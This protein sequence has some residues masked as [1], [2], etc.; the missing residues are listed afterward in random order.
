MGRMIPYNNLR[1]IQYFAVRLF[2]LMEGLS[3]II[4]FL[5]KYK[6]IF[7]IIYLIIFSSETYIELAVYKNIKLHYVIMMP[8]KWNMD[9]KNIIDWFNKKKWFKFTK[10][11]LGCQNTF[12]FFK[13]LKKKLFIIRISRVNFSKNL[14]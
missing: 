4:Y 7:W 1:N 12:F 6:L 8:K 14:L 13:P 10:K 9:K 3:I 5:C 11:I 2:G